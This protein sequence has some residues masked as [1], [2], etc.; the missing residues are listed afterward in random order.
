METNTKIYTTL[1]V[2]ILISLLSVMFLIWPLFEDIKK[3]S[4]NLIL[5]KDNIAVLKEQALKTEN[6]E[7]NYPIY[8]PNLQK[9][10][11]MF[12]DLNNPVDF[13][14]FLETTAAGLQATS[15]IS[16]PRSSPKQTNQ[17]FIIFQFSSKGSFS[18]I[19][20]F[21]KEVESGPYLIELEN[22]TIQNFQENQTQAA[23]K[24]NISK[25]YSARQVEAV[26]AIKVFTQK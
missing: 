18:N 15:Q 8:G 21:I 2:L 6:F 20:S 1:F 14:E 10:D 12:V 22:L 19:L 3:S 5:T 11:Q 23:S 9:I 4:E 24:K 7:N 13:I 26:L 17:N 16:L 25:D